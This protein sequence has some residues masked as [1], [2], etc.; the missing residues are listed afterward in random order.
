[1]VQHTLYWAVI[2]EIQVTEESATRI[3]GRLLIEDIMAEYFSSEE[4]LLSPIQYVAGS[5]QDRE[6]GV[7]GLWGFLVFDGDDNF[8]LSGFLIPVQVEDETKWF[9][10]SYEFQWIRNQEHEIGTEGEFSFETDSNLIPYSEIR[11][12]LNAA[13]ELV[14]SQGDH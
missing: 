5:Q 13:R 4:A 11:H 7:N 2:P 10:I 9:W 3:T 12:Y 14:E 1:M 8:Q 6:L